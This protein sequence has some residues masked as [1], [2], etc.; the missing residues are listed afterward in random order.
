M[1]LTVGS[2]V[3]PYQV[4]ALLGAGGM[5]EVYRARDTKL[6]RDVALKTLPER[7]AADPERRLRFEREAQSLAALSHPNIVTIHSVEQADGLLFLTMECVEGQP[8]SDLIAKG[9]LPLPRILALAI[10]LA[11]AVSAAHDKGITHRD[12]KPANVMVTADGRVKVL[13]FGLA[14]LVE[15]SPAEALATALPTAGVSSEG[16]IVGTVAYM[17]PEQA[18]GKRIDARSDIFSLGVLLYEMATGER[19]FTG[20]TPVST[21][22]SI[23]RDTPRAITE[24]NRALPRDLA[25]I[26]RRC[27]AKDPEQRTQSAKDLRNQL[28]DLKRTLDSGEL[29][30]PATIA[31]M[32]APIAHVAVVRRERVAWSIAAITIVAL[33]TGSVWALRRPVPTQPLV[34]FDVS[35]PASSDVTS[36]ALS[37]DGS[38]LVFAAASGGAPMLWV[39]RLDETT[40]RALTGTEGALYPFWKPDGQSIGFFADGKLK[41]VDV[42]GGALQVL[43]DASGGRGG[44][45]SSDDVILFTPGN[46]L[47]NPDSALMRIPATGGTPTPVTHLAAGEGSHRWP[48]FLPDG[49][50]FIFFSA[51]GS[52]DKNGVFLGALDGGEPIRLLAADGPALF[53]PPDTLLIVQRGVLR[54]VSFDPERGTITGDGLPVTDTVGTDVGIG[55]SAFSIANSEAL[56]YRATGGT[57]RRQLVWVDRTGTRRVLLGEPDDTSMASPRVDPSGRRVVMPRFDA[58]NRDVWVM[59]LVR[60]GWTRLTFDPAGDASPIWSADGRSVMYQSVRESPMSIF[61][62]PASG[63]GDPRLV[64][65]DAGVPLS[66]SHDGRFLLYQRQEPKTGTDLWA[67]PLGDERKP[68]PLAQTTFDERGGDFSPDGRWIAYESNESGRFEIYIRSFP[69]EGSKWPVSTGGGTQPRWR[70]DGK[71]LYYVAPDARLMAVSV[72]VSADGQTVDASA[73]VPLFA[74]RLASGAGFAPG[75]Q[76]YTVAPDGRFLLN[77]VVDE[78]SASPITVV[79]NWT[80]AS[81]K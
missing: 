73:P 36:F 65:R 49:R 28:E 31:G 20:E 57:E 11:D 13:D 19:P 4:H 70:R 69:A 47:A 74:T 27:L 52:P 71:E 16:R 79:L 77:T 78:A 5:G 35:T 8:L 14:K 29:S 54:A 64:L 34:R 80:A 12:L 23:L 51:F 68:V 58:G 53:A 15:P 48:Q 30:A 56:A 60:G 24:L 41:R 40:A 75:E 67:L 6:N 33:V 26:V 62:I 10:P 7:L 39:R 22:T 9:G 55:R 17:S 42:A 37:P 72:A 2:R 76:Q 32:P 44:A 61:E 81:R 3:G 43:A 46:A 63:V 50:R 38:Q 25:L 18:E 66:T 45:W 59:D 1:S 21:I